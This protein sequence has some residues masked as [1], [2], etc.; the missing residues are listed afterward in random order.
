MRQVQERTFRTFDG[1]ELFYRRWP[2]AGRSAG[3]IVMFHRG[4][5]HSGRMA[6][7]V[8]ELGLDEFDFYAWDARGH[9]RSQGQRGFS[10]SIGTSIRDVNEFVTHVAAESGHPVENV[11][12]IVGTCAVR[13][14]LGTDTS[15][16]RS[17]SARS[18]SAW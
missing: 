9:G 6:H 15:C 5:E 2:A 17:H 1:A 18:R 12:G 16:P 11:A 3:A 4:H 8:D 13:G 14:S 7:L 10:P